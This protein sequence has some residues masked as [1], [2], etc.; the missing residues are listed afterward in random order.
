MKIKIAL[1][2]ALLLACGS[3]GFAQSPTPT[4][5]EYAVKVEKIKNVRVNLKSH[6]DANRFRTNLRNA[7]KEGVNFAGHYILTTWGCGTNCTQSAIIDARNGRVYFP[8][9]LEG[10]GF[11]FCEL[12]DDAE[13][14]AYQADSRLLVLSGFKGGDLSRDNAPCG[15][16]YLEWTGRNFRQVR[17]VEKKRREAP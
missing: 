16:Y 17:F 9:Q 8:G 15:I 11:G 7:A 14:V 13:P 12:P 10:A 3:I 2:A 4:P 6:R 5:T 1:L